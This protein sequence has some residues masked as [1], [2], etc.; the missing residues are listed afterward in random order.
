M[1]T[2]LQLLLLLKL[3]L[4]HLASE[5]LESLGGYVS[6]L[7]NGQLSVLNRQLHTGVLP[8]AKT[9]ITRLTSLPHL[10]LRS[11]LNIVALI[12]RSVNHITHQSAQTS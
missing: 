11:A 12:Y 3:I 9:L 1:K 7:P 4:K 8:V 2:S 10:S 6:S 5:L